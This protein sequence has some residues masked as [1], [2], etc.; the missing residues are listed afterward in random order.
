MKYIMTVK[1]DFIEQYKNQFG[2]IPNEENLFVLEKYPPALK[3][4]QG[5]VEVSK[6]TLT[7]FAMVFPAKITVG[8]V[9][10]EC[11]DIMM[12]VGEAFYSIEGFIEEAKRLGVSKRIN[13]FPWEFNPSKNKVWLLLRNGAKRSEGGTLF[14]V[15]R[16][17]KVELI[18]DETVKDKLQRLDVDIIKVSV[19][20]AALEEVRG[21]G[22]RKIGGVYFVSEAAFDSVLTIT[23]AIRAIG[24]EAGGLIEINPH[25][26]TNISYFRG[27]KY[28]DDEFVRRACGILAEGG[29]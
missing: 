7:H 6:K 20:G 24:C 10:T 17:S 21:C 1:T 15:F 22:Y 3:W 23:E 13:R 11:R 27:T 25:I 19:K 8:S 4:K 5:D 12:Y 28:A 2:I 26:K 9:A 29:A 14:G 18:W 16:V